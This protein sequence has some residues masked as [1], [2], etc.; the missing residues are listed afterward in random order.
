MPE[1][2]TSSNVEFVANGG[3][4]SGYLSR[5]QREGRHPSIVLIQEWWGLDDH[6]KDVTH[7]FAGEGYVTLAP[8][9]F[10]G[11][12]TAEPTEA[13]KLAQSMDQA[14]VAKEL[15]GA[16]A[17]LKG[18]DFSSGK[19]GIIGYCMGGGLAISTACK[20]RDLDACVV[21]YG[22]SPNP[23]DQVQSIS[24]PVLGIFAEM[25]ER[26][27]ATLDALKEAMQ[28][29]G[30]QFE[31]HMYPGA[32]HAFFNDTRPD[33]HSPEASQDAWAKTLTFFKENL[34]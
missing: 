12:V 10:H 3:T 32:Q 7:R 33:V 18:Q 21:Y 34:S 8:D 4:A 29:Y 14:R 22:R 1:P 5:P 24:C 28:Q 13:M 6:I 31:M 17:Y 20:N 2:I 19:A 26:T 30:K 9:L 23:V 16:V 25:D 27:N 15:S 11:Q